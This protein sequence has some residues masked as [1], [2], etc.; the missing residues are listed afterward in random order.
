MIILRYDPIWTFARVKF[1]ENRYMDC[2]PE[3]ENCILFWDVHCTYRVLQENFY[4]FISMDSNKSVKKFLVHP[5]GMPYLALSASHT[6]VFHVVKLE[7]RE[8][9]LFM[10]L[11]VFT[12]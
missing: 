4:T 12:P 5:V 11:L 6:V 8:I 3:L 9:I 7:K 2:V 1:V 10:S